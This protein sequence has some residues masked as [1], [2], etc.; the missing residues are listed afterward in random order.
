M[1]CVRVGV[2]EIAGSVFDLLSWIQT[3]DVVDEII[4]SQQ[5][6]QGFIVDGI[7][8]LIE[9]CG[10]GLNLR[11]GNFAEAERLVEIGL[12]KI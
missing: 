3:C 2:G 8:R 9:F 4:L 10:D 12:H 5:C 6:L 11:V 1:I 7:D